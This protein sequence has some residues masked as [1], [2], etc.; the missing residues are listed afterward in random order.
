MVTGIHHVSLKCASAAEFDKTVSFYRD[1]LGM[2]VDREWEGGIM[3]D[4]GNGI[5]E[6]FANAAD[7][8]A[9]GA[10]RHVALAVDEVDQLVESIRQAGYAV[11]MEPK[12]IDLVGLKAR[13]AFVVGPVQEEI[14][15]F[16]VMN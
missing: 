12:D 10:W 16:C 8:P 13:I 15:F 1:L 9:Q 11:I 4:T 5:V 6:I 14:E 2:P 7:H 3:L